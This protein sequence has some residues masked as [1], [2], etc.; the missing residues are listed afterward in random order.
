MRNYIYGLLGCLTALALY[1]F[2]QSQ[3]SDYR[4]KAETEGLIYKLEVLQKSLENGFQKTGEF[5]I[6]SSTVTNSEDLKPVVLKN[7]TIIVQG[8][9]EG[10]LLVLTPNVE[11]G[12]VH[13]RCYVGPDR[14][15]P[16]KCRSE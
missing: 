11:D 12:K 3:Y 8:R 9:S 16:N 1:S 2:L 5:S 4:A 7:G 6:S 15:R 13:W 10:Q 14:A